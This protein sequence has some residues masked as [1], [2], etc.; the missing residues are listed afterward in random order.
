[1]TLPVTRAGL[2]QLHD[3]GREAFSDLEVTT[4][5]LDTL[6]ACDPTISALRRAPRPRQKARTSIWVFCPTVNLITYTYSE[7]QDQPPSSNFACQEGDA[8]SQRPS[9]PLYLIRSRS[10]VSEVRVP[11]CSIC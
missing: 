5:L 9:S 2:L 8:R 6:R 11:S 1:M 10:N 3:A 4:R 7:G